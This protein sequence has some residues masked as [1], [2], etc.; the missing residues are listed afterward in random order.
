[1]TPYR[2]HLYNRSTRDPA[3]SSLA[4]G[5]WAT[6]K[7]TAFLAVVGVAGWLFFRDQVQTRLRPKVEATVNNALTGTGIETTIGGARFFEAKG[8]LLSNM[9]ASAPN[10]TL[11]AYETWLEMPSNTTDL[12]TGNVSVNG[13]EM[14]RVQLEIVRSV[15]API[16]LSALKKLVEKISQSS[17]G[18]SGKLVPI[19]MLD[20]QIRFVD[21]TTG[22]EKLISDINLRMTPVDHN[23]RMILEIVA[24]AAAIEVRQAELKGIVDPESGEWKAELSLD[25]AVVGNG[26]MAILPRD[27]QQRL[28]GL[29]SFDSRVG[30]KVYAHGNWRNGEL[31][32]IE[33]SGDVRRLAVQHAKSPWPIRDASATWTFSPDGAVVNDIRGYLGSSPFDAQFKTSSLDGPV[34]WRFKGALAGLKLDNSDRSIA[35]MPKSMHQFLSD[36][37]PRGDFDIQYDFRFDGQRLSK[38]IDTQIS[39]FAFNLNR[40]PYPMSNCDGLARW[41]D[42]QIVYQLKY[43]TRDQLLTA[44][45]TV[46]NPGKMATWTCDLNIERGQLPFDEKLQKGFDANPPLARIV[47]AFNAHGWIAGSGRL[48]KPTPGG[49]V[50]KQFDIELIDLT[51]NHDN[52][53]YTIESVKG[54]IQT[55]NKSLRFEKITGQSGIASLVCNGMWNL[56]DGLSVL[57]NCNN[58]QMDERLRLALRPELK[59]VWDGYR[60]KGTV[61]KMA[62]KMT[63]PPG[64]KECNVVVD[65]TL[66]G[67]SKGIRSSDLSINPTWF[68]YE[69]N[70]LAGR[71]VVGNGKVTLREFQGQHGHTKVVCNGDGSYS[72]DGWDVRLSD[73]LALSL[74]TDA[75][76][77]RALPESLST[78]IEYMK[79]DG[80]L[81]VQGTMTL[82][83][84]YRKP[85]LQYASNIPAQY[86]WHPQTNSY[87]QQAAATE[88][89]IPGLGTPRVS[90]GWDLRFDMNQAEMFLGIPLKNV[91]GMFELIGQYDGEN[92]DCRGSV[93]LD[94]LTIYGAQITQVQGPVWFDN[95]QALAGGLINQVSRGSQSPS[96]KGQMYGGLVQ[97]DAAISSDREGRFLIQTSLA[98]G[99]LYELCKEFSPNIENV[100]GRTFAALTMEG[101][102]SGYHTCK[103]NGKI[104]L[105]DARIYELP[106]VVRLLKLFQVRSVDDDSAF[107]SGDIF[108][109]VNGENID[110]NRMEFNGDA[111]SIIGN[112]RT[113]FDH[114]LDL[115]FYSVVGRNR[116][117]I[118]LISDLYRRSSQKF[119]WINVGGTAQNPKVSKEILPELN[120]SMRQLFQQ[121]IR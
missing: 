47:R 115:N 103:G 11:T 91:F 6:T 50:Q 53:P 117:N 19:S 3:P 110:I 96:I 25:D 49:E 112:G 39:N 16:D 22:T 69:L 71:L 51:M 42:D 63:L 56:H 64:K 72:N 77:L 119:M 120:G 5:A 54:K 41:V 66:H 82:A 74:R 114:D 80:L 59:D 89:V 7:L 86:Q 61:E 108:F 118:P 34:A 31:L 75:P 60:P 40:F 30:G 27:I 36:L 95:Y 94:S 13:I 121:E 28:D 65:A 84:Q 113:N 48:A 57:Y 88:Q 35:S 32:W 83:G 15:D 26:L 52:F 107:D 1:M 9:K 12:V 81:N 116:I 102:A 111:I 55:F 29:Q 37:R 87:T 43:E 73:L 8:M 18:R 67:E 109:N 33:G 90:M 101:N 20:S 98:D 85:K 58:V 99:N 14:R 76:L 21:Q 38:T 68:P 92:V 62:V 70:N 23:G 24:T 45:G 44:G 4:R 79:F 93:N 2:A 105:R 46:N 104:H 10:I 17:N 78:P 100:E 97:L 106:P